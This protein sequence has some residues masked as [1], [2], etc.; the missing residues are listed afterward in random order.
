MTLAWEWF[1]EKSE[2]WGPAD[3][4]MIIMAAGV[5]GFLV[6]AG[7]SLVIWSM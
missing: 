3:L 6:L 7:C 1:T 4:A 5:A 2:S